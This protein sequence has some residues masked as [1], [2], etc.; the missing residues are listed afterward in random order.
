MKKYDPKSP[1]WDP[2]VTKRH[3]PCPGN[4]NF[5]FKDSPALSKKEKDAKGVGQLRTANRVL[6]I[7]IVILSAKNCKCDQPSVTATATQTLT[8]VNG[9][10]IAGKD[11]F[12]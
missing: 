8:L 6:K 2:L 12:I 9:V 7:R 3:K 11:D 10:G 4:D 5:P 1:T